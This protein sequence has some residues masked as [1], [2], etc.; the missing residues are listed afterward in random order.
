MNVTFDTVF[1]DSKTFFYVKWDDFMTIKL[2]IQIIKVRK[3][4][5]SRR[6]A[7]LLYIRINA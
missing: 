6:S 3:N 7:V 1:N 2:L 5:G 4:R